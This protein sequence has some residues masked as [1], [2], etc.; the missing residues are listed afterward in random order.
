MEQAKFTRNLIVFL[1]VKKYIQ[2]VSLDIIIR[3]MICNFSFQTDYDTNLDFMAQYYI[4]SGANII[5]NNVSIAA[6][7]VHVGIKSTLLELR[8]FYIP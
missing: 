8:F 4:F 7:T 5:Q 3:N 6:E 2:N 1:H